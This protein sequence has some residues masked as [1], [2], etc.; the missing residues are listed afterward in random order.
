M[1]IKQN[2]VWESNILLHENNNKK[3]KQKQ[4]QNKKMESWFSHK[5]VFC[6]QERYFEVYCGTFT[7]YE[8]RLIIILG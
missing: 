8:D 3:Q 7:Y 1:K 2:K 4:K 6:R 5:W